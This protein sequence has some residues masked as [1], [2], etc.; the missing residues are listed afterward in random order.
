MAGSA[1]ALAARANGATVT[2]L[3]KG[4]GATA[5]CGGAVWGEGSPASAALSASG[6]FQPVARGAWLCSVR[7]ELQRAGAALPAQAYGAVRPGH[8]VAVVG[9]RGAPQLSDASWAAA[10]LQAAGVEATAV[11]LAL[12]LTTCEVRRSPFAW[13]RDLDNPPALA[14]LASAINR[15]DQSFDLILLPPFIGFEG[16]ALEQLRSASGRAL[17][18]LLATV[19]SVPGLRLSRALEARV[20][21]AGCD[22]QVGEVIALHAGEAR[23]S[24]GG[25]IAFDQAVLASGRFLGGGLRRAGALVEPLLGLPLFVGDCG[26]GVAANAGARVDPNVMVQS[27]VGQRA[28]D[29]APIFR[30]GVRVDASFRPFDADGQP[31]AWARAVGSILA[32]PDRGLGFAIETG[33]A[34]GQWAARGDDSSLQSAV[35]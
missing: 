16:P 34:G 14:R 18:E 26:E 2:V 32:G 11:E 12:D 22:V 3:T 29:D 27:L 9:F 35:A 5:F 1:A 20:R 24:T 19:P 13:A 31:V 23:L 30:L 17:G 8:R 25:A 10:G 33:A 7:G 4:P 28:G 15:L 6:L 21:G